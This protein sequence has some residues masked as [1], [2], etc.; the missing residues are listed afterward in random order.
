MFVETGEQIV[1]GTGPNQAFAEQPDRLGIRHLLRQGQT[2]K[3]HKRQP[4][5]DHELG[6]SSERL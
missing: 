4:V 6:L 3:P 1:D 5:L 2:M